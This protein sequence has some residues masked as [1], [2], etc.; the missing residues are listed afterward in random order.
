M[1]LITTFLLV[2][3]A[4]ITF[5]LVLSLQTD[6]PTWLDAV[7]LPFRCILLGGLGGAVYCLR[8]I[9][10]NA[11]VHKQ[12]D[13]TWVPW[14]YIRPFVSLACGGISFLFLK[15]GLLLL[16]STQNADSTDLGFYALAFVA[17]LNVDKFITKIEDIA[18]AT[19]GI[20][21]SRT[22]RDSSKEDK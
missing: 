7:R 1:K 21:K 22:A 14:Y 18:Q 6:L 19:W 9:Y 12:W 2:F 8:G 10:L 3:A 11:S 20:E 17:G 16:E 15:A 4:G 13:A 5:L